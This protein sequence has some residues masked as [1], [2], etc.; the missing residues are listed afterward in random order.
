MKKGISY[1]LHE[2]QGKELMVRIDLGDLKLPDVKMDVEEYL[3]FKISRY[4]NLIKVGDREEKWKI[5]AHPV[6]TAFASF[7][8]ADQVKIVMFMLNTHYDINKFMEQDD[9]IGLPKFI[10]GISAELA[11]LD[12]EI[13]LWGSLRKFVED[14]NIPLGDY[15]KAGTRHQDTESMTFTAE[16]GLGVTTIA[17]LCKML[18]PIFGTIM[19]YLI[20]EI[21]VQLK[22]VHCAG[23]LTNIL[24]NRCHDLVIKLRHYIQNIANKAIQDT[25]TNIFHNVSRENMLRHIVSNTYV[26]AFININ[27]YFDDGNIMKFIIVTI[28]QIVRGR[29]I[30]A[31]KEAFITR[32]PFSS[33]DGEEGTKANIEIDSQTSRGTC[34]QAILPMVSAVPMIDRFLSDYGIT[35]KAFKEAVTWYNKNPITPNPTNQYVVNHIF[36]T[37]LGGWPSIKLLNHTTYAKLVALAQLIL[38]QKGFYELLTMLSAVP[39]AEPKMTLTPTDDKVRLSAK[40]SEEYRTCRAKSD[41]SPLKDGGK[42]WDRMIEEYLETILHYD[43]LHNTANSLW[44]SMGDDNFNGR[45]IQVTQ[46][47]IASI[48]TLTLIEF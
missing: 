3:K 41:A 14:G 12:K 38:L 48:C 24:S 43:Y 20:R 18:A 5:L 47:L 27:L 29:E 23:I 13:D 10:N 37:Y 6:N 1:V 28:K 19:A 17:L 34:D 36:G 2:E 25:Q 39:A 26:R 40:T 33:G 31:K 7:S 35:K 4:R 8:E 32:M 45:K 21:D 16:H 44:E 46:K 30:H 9:I 22:E 15:S 11:K 42:R